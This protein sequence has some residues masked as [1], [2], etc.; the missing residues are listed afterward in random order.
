MG[1]K[2]ITFGDIKVKKHKFHYM[3]ALFSYTM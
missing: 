1:E 3:K 2:I